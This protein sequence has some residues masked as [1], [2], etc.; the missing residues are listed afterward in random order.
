MTPLGSLGGQ[1]RKGAMFGIK[2][3]VLK[4][5]G[6]FYNLKEF[7]SPPAST[8]LLNGVKRGQPVKIAIL[9]QEGS[10]ND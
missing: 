5:S 9:S 3:K 6:R 1:H 7:H 4:R 10:V 2:L 8:P